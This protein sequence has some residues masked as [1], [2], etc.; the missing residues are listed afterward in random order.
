L[1]EAKTYRYF[2]HTSDDDDRSY[3]TR[4]EVEEAKQKDPIAVFAETLKDRGIL[5]PASIDALWTETKA[6]VDGQIDQA[7]NAADPEPSSLER[8]VYFEGDA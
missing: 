6:N 1:I 7:W 2:P 3:R 5:D 8:H 4:E